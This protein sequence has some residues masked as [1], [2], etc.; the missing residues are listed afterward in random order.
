[1]E[2]LSKAPGSKGE[3]A[4]ASTTDAKPPQHAAAAPAPPPARTSSSAVRTSAAGP[5]VAAAGSSV[6]IQIVRQ[7]GTGLGISVAG[8]L[9]S[10]PFKESDPV[11]VHSKR[12]RAHSTV[13]NI[14]LSA[15]DQ[16]DSQ[17]STSVL[18][19]SIIILV[20]VHTMYVPK[21]VV[22]IRFNA[23]TVQYTK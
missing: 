2:L 3:P 7:P 4:S 6:S 11:H 15:P 20:L 5:E 10:T 8:G 19:S 21:T 23:S 14:L 12:T 1:M 18:K 13:L 17:R 16:L 9:G 22:R